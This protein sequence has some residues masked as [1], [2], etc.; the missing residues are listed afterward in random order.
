[1]SITRYQIFSRFIEMEE[2]KQM[3]EG[4]HPKYYEAKVTCN[5]G[6]VFTTGSTK[7]EIHVEICSKC[8]RRWLRLVAVLISSTR[9]TDLLLTTNI[10]LRRS[11]DSIAAP[12]C[13]TGNKEELWAE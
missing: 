3:R 13:V 6:N 8:R 9:S 2:V 10:E 7:E 5:C 4:I 1:M 12:F 11:C